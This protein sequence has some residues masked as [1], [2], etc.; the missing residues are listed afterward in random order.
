MDIILRARNL[1]FRYQENATLNLFNRINLTLEKGKVTLLR[2]ASGCGKSTLAYVLSGLYPE[3]GGFLETGEVWVLGHNIHQI[4]PFERVKLIAM[5]FQNCDLQFCMS[6]LKRELQFCLENLVVPPEE[7]ETKIQETAQKIGVESLLTRQFSTLSGGEKQRC[8]LA[9]LF[10]IHPQVMVLDEAFANLDQ[11]TAK[12]L[13]HLI[14]ESGITVLAIDHNR[15]LWEGAIDQELFLPYDINQT[16]SQPAPKNLAHLSSQISLA[17][18]RQI[19][20]TSPLLAD[21]ERSCDHW[22]ADRVAPVTKPA[23]IKTTALVLRGLHIPALT[24]PQ[25]F[26]SAF[27]GKSGSG[28][29]TLFHAFMKQLPYEGQILIDG[30]ELR[31]I[32]RRKLY[33]EC[34]I[35]FQNP[36]NQ[37]LA[38]SV[39]DEIMFSVRRWYP[40]KDPHWQKQKTLALLSQFKLEKYRYFSPYCLSQGQQR[41]LAVLTMLVGK[42]SILLLDEPTYGQDED[43]TKIMMELLEE[44]VKNGLTVIF[45]THNEKVVSQYAQHVERIE[46]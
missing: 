25:G 34:G 12:A 31:R 15:S 20:L 35:V 43:N 16:A 19:T 23:Q 10:L 13:I 27:L 18:N 32:S 7:W 28:K 37:F 33:R 22:P 24:F 4:P 44:R 39:F 2:G 8:A 46:E 30:K 40:K 9:C 17:S 21:G 1:T 5:L 42:Q 38:L 3:N 11:A 41:R 29:T 45:T 14:K 26:I 6:D 36:A